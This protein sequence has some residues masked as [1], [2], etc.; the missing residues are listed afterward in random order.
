MLR[1]A[2]IGRRL[3]VQG[4]CE[5]S[6]RK[7]E[8]SGRR[9]FFQRVVPAEIV[10]T[11]RLHFGVEMVHQHGSEAGEHLCEEPVSELHFRSRMGAKQYLA[12]AFSRVSVRA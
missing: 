5:L 7:G 6:S 10:S 1:D 3:T 11:K 12:K 9:T 2:H 4:L 8:C